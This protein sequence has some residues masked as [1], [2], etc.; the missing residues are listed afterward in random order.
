[1]DNYTLVLCTVKLAE[2]QSIWLSYLPT[3]T[4]PATPFIIGTFSDTQLEIAGNSPLH[5]HANS[6]PEAVKPMDDH[7][8]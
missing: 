6:H 8:G 1:M 2:V 3:P 7:I 5:Y 4:I